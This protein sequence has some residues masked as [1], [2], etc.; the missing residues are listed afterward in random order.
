[1]PELASNLVRRPVTVIAAVGG[2]P[3]A[4]AAKAATGTVPIVFGFG[5]D[6]VQSGVVASLSS[7]V[8]SLR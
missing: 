1:L 7:N 5:G 2:V 3:V 6:P 8:G 4:L